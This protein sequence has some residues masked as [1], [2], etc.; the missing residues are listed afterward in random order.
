MA[1]VCVLW[2]FLVILAKKSCGG[3]WTGTVT[4][5]GRAKKRDAKKAHI[6]VR[7]QFRNWPLFVLSIARLDAMAFM[8][9]AEKE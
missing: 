6:E 4:E 2:P 8:R 7:V 1:G 9:T 3:P 5:K